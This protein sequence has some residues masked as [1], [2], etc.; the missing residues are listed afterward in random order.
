M[1]S[2]RSCLILAAGL[3]LAI[4]GGC[5]S[6]H[7]NESAW[8]SPGAMY[9]PQDENYEIKGKPESGGGAQ[10]GFGGPG[11]EVN[12]QALEADAIA[13]Q[14]HYHHHV[15]HHY[16]TPSGTYTVPGY[17]HATYMVPHHAPMPAYTSPYAHSPNGGNPV[18]PNGAAPWQGGYRGGYGGGWGTYNPWINNGTGGLIGSDGD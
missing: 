7:E 18:G 14:I 4:A 5:A 17:A 3:P 16:H 9:A 8:I 11:G 6:T 10:A 13:P 1:A 15:H 2:L 12:A